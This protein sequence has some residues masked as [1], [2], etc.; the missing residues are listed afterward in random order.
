MQFDAISIRLPYDAIRLPYDAIRLPYDAIG[1]HTIFPI[2]LEH[3]NR[4]F[5]NTKSII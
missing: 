4:N 1:L 5:E 3:K 2:I